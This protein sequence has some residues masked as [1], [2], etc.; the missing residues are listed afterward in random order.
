[1]PI[2]FSFHL[3]K[4]L[5]RQQSSSELILKT[6]GR[7]VSVSTH[8][9]YVKTSDIKMAEYHKVKKTQPYTW[10]TNSKIGFIGSGKI[11]QSI[12]QALVKKNFFSPQNI[13]A[14]DTN[15]EYFDYL[16]NEC[17]IF[18]VILI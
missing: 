5:T 10:P 2:Y 14:S 9:A 8:F 16:K 17:D 13:Y 3:R 1:M 11:A 7:N 18:K 4:F 15:T 6:N 12:I